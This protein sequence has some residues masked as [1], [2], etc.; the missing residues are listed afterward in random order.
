VIK[1]AKSFGKVVVVPRFGTEGAE[2]K[3]SR[4]D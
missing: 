4:P 2:F 3:S 1:F